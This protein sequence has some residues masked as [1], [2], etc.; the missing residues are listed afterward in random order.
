MKTFSFKI[1]S[2]GEMTV[3]QTGNGTAAAKACIKVC[4]LSFIFINYW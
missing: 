1:M 4:P 3:L 2:P